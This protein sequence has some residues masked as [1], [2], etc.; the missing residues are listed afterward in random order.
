MMSIIDITC[1]MLR[2][3]HLMNLNVLLYYS[4]SRLAEFVAGHC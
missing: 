4:L 3:A 2:V 1:T